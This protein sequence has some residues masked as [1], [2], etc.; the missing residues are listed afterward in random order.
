M[1]YLFLFSLLFAFQAG[2]QTKSAQL[3]LE[4]AVFRNDKIGVLAFDVIV[5]QDLENFDERDIER[6]KV[7]V[8]EATFGGGNVELTTSFL[9]LKRDSNPVAED[10]RYAVNQLQLL[11]ARITNVIPLKKG[12]K[13]TLSAH[14]GVGFSV[15]AIVNGDNEAVR[16]AEYKLFKLAREC[17]DCVKETIRQVGYF[18]VEAGIKVQLNKDNS[19]IAFAGDYRRSGKETT[20][21]GENN[22]PLNLDP[23]R[24]R[25][26]E[27]K[28]IIPLSFELGHQIAS[29]P[30][31]VYARG[32]R[33]SYHSSVD[34][35]YTGVTIPEYAERDTSHVAFR[36]GVR[37]KFKG[38]FR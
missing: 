1:K 9:S 29:G 19:Y 38:L 12:F 21:P 3:E 26:T 6:L 8:L 17:M 23:Y 32:E 33:I 22:I 36:I 4:S 14:A 20:I 28:T 7:S 15:K 18:P 34:A 25:I 5:D 31:T 16:E 10:E 27:N 2:A 37:V 24:A 30:V 13:I 11:S 35:S